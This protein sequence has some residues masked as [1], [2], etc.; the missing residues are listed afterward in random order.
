MLHLKSTK[1]KKT[2]KTNVQFRHLLESKKRFAVLQGGT[3][4]GK[5]FAVCQYIAYLIR[6][7]KEP[8]I[9]SI[10]RKTLPA[11]KGSVQRDLISILEEMGII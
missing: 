10:I 8:L 9:I 11:L 1:E 2:L 6:T 5:T 3:R 4:S 7:T